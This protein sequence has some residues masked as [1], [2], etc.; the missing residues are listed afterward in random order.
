[1]KHVKLETI[2]LK[3]SPEI[4]EAWV[5]QVI[6]DDPSILGLG[7]VMPRDKE[8]IQPNAGRLDILLQDTETD[9]RYE[10]EIQLGSTNESHI[11]RTI[12]YWDLERKRYPQYDH[13]A[14]IVAEDITSR[15]LNVISLFNGFIPL[16]AIQMSAI[17]S[18][19]GIG[20]FF[21]KVL[22]ELTLGRIDED[23]EVNIP[24][25]RDYW[26]KHGTKQTVEMADKLLKIIQD[27]APGY[28]LKYNKYYIGLEING[29]PNNFVSFRPKKQWILTEI[30]LSENKELISQ[31]EESGLDAE[32]LIKWG[33]YRLRLRTGDIEKKEELI[34]SVFKLAYDASQS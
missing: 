21:T 16:I 7:D 14:V 28:K 25:D 22:G 15:F 20:L 30:R 13:C 6:Y 8:R 11:I 27:V 33:I 26:L 1:M 2:S 19:D 3:N 32:F 12:E 18:E 29:S 17:K 24:A 5:Q 23:E 10:V 34:K 31:L 9:K 4:N